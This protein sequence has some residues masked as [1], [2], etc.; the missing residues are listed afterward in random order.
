MSN[1]LLRW[2]FGTGERGGD[3]LFG[4]LGHDPDQPPGLELRERAGL[5][6]L[7]RIAG[8]RLV[9]FV[10]D[11][12]DRAALDVLAVA[13]GLD[14]ARDLDAASLVHLVARHDAGLDAAVAPNDRFG[15]RLL[16]GHPSPP[17]AKRPL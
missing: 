11:I 6:D 5:H 15:L 14:Q 17:P 10:V 2:L 16:L 7:D 4:R 3:G 1:V 12:T 9:L 13:R 8:T